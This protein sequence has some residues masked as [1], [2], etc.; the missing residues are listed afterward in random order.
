MSGTPSEAEVQTQLKNVVDLLET[1]RAYADG[2]VAGSGG[3]LDVLYQS[4]EGEYTPFG[5]TDAGATFRAG[6]SSILSPDVVRSMVDPILFEYARLIG[7]GGAYSGADDLFQALYE[8]FVA[9]SLSVQ[10]RAIT[11]DTTATAGGG[12]VGNG[13]VAR[14]TVD[15]EGFPLEA[16]HVETKTLRCRRDQ[17]SGTEEDEEE[18]EVLGT[19]ASQD[20]LLIASY[21]SGQAGQRFIRVRN[22][23]SGAGGSLLRNSS[24]S[25][26]SASGTPKFAG[27]TETAGG[28]QIEQNT[29]AFYRT[30]P[31][32]TV[33]ASLRINGG[34]GNVTLTQPL[35]SMRQRT[36]DFS[37][38]YFLR[39]MLNKTVGSAVG[40]T[41]TISMGGTS[42]SV[43]IG[44]LGANWQ[45]LVVAFDENAWPKV[46]NADPMTVVVQWHSST[47]GYLLV[48]DVI[49]TPYDEVDGTYWLIR[50]NAATPTPF[51]VDDTLA[52]T[53]T[54]GAPATGKIQWWLWRGGY[55]YLPS[56]GTP[57]LADPS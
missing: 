49:F 48:D 6:L 32:A 20:S 41:V 17:N 44:S 23:G 24:F 2:T 36:L 19:A 42:A 46:F 11:Y 7:F 39:A 31:R 50:G 22:A 8:H 25:D 28:A 53:D 5:L 38:P 12:N 37:R 16:C 55:G 3:L 45:E 34:G 33:N 9:N 26:Y 4:L 54:G 10:S 27:W 51:L 35:S 52:F 57:T 43:S 30:H 56:A 15:D 29:A 1:T 13:A 14:V 21:G 40:G 18:F 47:S